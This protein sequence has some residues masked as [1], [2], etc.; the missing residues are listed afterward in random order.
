MASDIPRAR[1]RSHEPATSTN[2]GSRGGYDVSRPH[3]MGLTR[4]AV[5]SGTGGNGSPTVPVN[6]ATCG[7]KEWRERRASSD[8]G[9]RWGRELASWAGGQGSSNLREGL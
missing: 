5:W 8:G 7:K 2:G 3:L 4:R 9:L 1:Q 6:A